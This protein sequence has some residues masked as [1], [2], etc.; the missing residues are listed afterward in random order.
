MEKVDCMK[1]AL[2]AMSGGVDSSVAASLMV[3]KGYECIGVTMKLDDNDDIGIEKSNTCCSVEDTQ[4]AAS[5]AHKLGM[6]YY[7]F[8]FKDDF[9]S[10]VIKRF[11]ETTKAE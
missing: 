7:V 4:D 8:N 3:E 1:K 10:K 9:E 6:P 11:I 2:I 5:V